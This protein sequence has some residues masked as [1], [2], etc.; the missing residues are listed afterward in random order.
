VWQLEKDLPGAQKFHGN[1]MLLFLHGK[2]GPL[3]FGHWSKGKYP[4]D[5]AYLARASP[6]ERETD[7]SAII[8][9]LKA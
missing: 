4:A 8:V 1:M 6:F 2:T 3:K 5:G 9:N 7:G